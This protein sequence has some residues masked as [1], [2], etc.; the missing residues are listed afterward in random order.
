MWTDEGC[1][2][3]D[4]QWRGRD[5]SLV[6]EEEVGRQCIDVGASVCRWRLAPAETKAKQIKQHRP[7]TRLFKQLPSEPPR[8]SV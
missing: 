1:A 5:H 8:R 6:E 7:D 3:K 4:R 2:G